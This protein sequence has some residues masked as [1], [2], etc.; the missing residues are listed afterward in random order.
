[1]LTLLQKDSARVRSLTLDSPLPTFI[2]VDEDEP[3][4]LN[5]ALNI[6]FCHCEKD[7]ANKELYGN[8]KEKF[9]QYFTSIVGKVFSIPHVE[10]GTTD[11]LMIQYAKNE[12]LDVIENNMLDF[13]KIKDAR[14]NFDTHCL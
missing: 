12:L 6:L 13:T 3:A 1:M 4:N 10:R 7:S 8:L 9:Q 11:T 5:E 2:S 14:H